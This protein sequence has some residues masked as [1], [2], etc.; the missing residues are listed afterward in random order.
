MSES[1]P[2]DFDFD[3]LRRAMDECGSSPVILI[4]AKQKPRIVMMRLIGQALVHAGYKAFILFPPVLGIRAEEV[5]DTGT[6]PC[7]EIRQPDLKKLRDAAVFISSEQN[8]VDGPQ[9]AKRF[10][11]YHSLPDKELKRDY[12]QML[13]LKPIPATA[14]DYFAILVKQTPE[15]WTVENYA[16]HVDGILPAALLQ[17]R[18]K[19]LAI[20]P[21]GYPKIDQMMKLD[22]S[23]IP[24]DTIT[25]A[26]T[27][28][29]IGG[30]SAK[31]KGKEILTMLLD[32]FPDYRIAFRPYPGPDRDRLAEVIDA[33]QSHPRFML[34]ETATG[35][36]VMHRSA[37]V[38]SDHSSMAVSFGLGFGRPVVFFRVEGLKQ[39]RN[40]GLE[41]VDPI[42]VRAG[43][44]PAL[45]SGVQKMLEQSDDIAARVAER[46]ADILYNPG[47][48]I[49]YLVEIMPDILADRSRPD[50]LEIPRRPFIGRSAADQTAQFETLRAK[51][52]ALRPRFPEDILNRL[53][54]G[55]ALSADVPKDGSVVSNH[56]SHRS[57]VGQGLL[58]RSK[59]LI[60]GWRRD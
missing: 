30:G 6:V 42:G 58:K 51:L 32:S 59:S 14:A 55:F 33:F 47:R 19:T 41:P 25:Y 56:D 29:T 54:E 57:S 44:I 1:K 22:T 52:L 5:D 60:K 49:D 40:D 8:V 27:Q 36:E 11:I 21:F 10:G 26:P 31:R 18:R 53:E 7:F 2:N 48:S 23:A 38:V 46:R 45:Q 28:T 35:E 50:W 12:A 15:N 20:V 37:V 39:G 13:A 24:R 9:E 3:A 17:G 34:D 43:T 16:P 4:W